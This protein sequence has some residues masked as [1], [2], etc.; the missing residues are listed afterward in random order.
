MTRSILFKSLVKPFYRQNAG[1]FIFVF[2]VFLGAVGEVGGEFRYTGPIL[3]LEYQ[4]AMIQGMLSAPILFVLVLLAW[5]LYNE[6]CAR[7]VL[8][9]LNAPEYA[10]LD[11]LNRLDPKKLFGALLVVQVILYLPVSLYSI[12]IIGVACY[13][14]WWLSAFCIPAY[15]L[16]L[17]CINAAR[18]Q[19]LCQNP[20]KQLS[21]GISGWTRL[22]PGAQ[23][24]PME[25][26]ILPPKKS[27]VFRYW[28]YFIRYALRD[29]KLLLSGIKLFS[30]G[31]LYFG[32]NAVTPDDYDLRM[33]TLLFC[34]GLFGHGVLIYQ[35][36]RMEE[37]RLAFYRG[38]PVSLAR[39]FSAY[40][41][42]Y[43]VL[44]IPE[45]IIFS[46]L[47]PAPLHTGDALKLLLSA[48]S[49]LLL[50]N[51][52]LFLAPIPVRDY[53]KIVGCLFLLL[54]FSVLAGVL[55]WLAGTVLATAALLFWRR[56]YRYEATDG[57]D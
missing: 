8:D 15:I 17:C 32:M 6:K 53:L 24:R 9:T 12:A 55:I 51:S 47:V 28:P 18:F 27:P 36:R 26:R 35:F 30:C 4:Y 45:M 2:I 34:I 21:T 3:Q 48:Y 13:K 25:S 5:L 29:Q 16:L 52:F 42:L 57:E 38:L 7:F 33:P 49:F 31:V 39:R 44:M 11:V 40:A 23:I 43:G 54:Y 46:R 37:K 1:Q 10:F 50:L 41:L 20:G 56:Y 19:C 14:H 22:L